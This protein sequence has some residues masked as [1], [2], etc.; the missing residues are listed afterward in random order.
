MYDRK[1]FIEFKFNEE[2]RIPFIEKKWNN[3]Q[4]YLIIIV[5]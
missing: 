2:N 3:Y 1:G 5:H 4:N